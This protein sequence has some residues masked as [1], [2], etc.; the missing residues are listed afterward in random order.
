MA[1]EHRSTEEAHLDA[2]RGLAADGHVK[3]DGGSHVGVLRGKAQRRC[4]C[5]ERRRAERGCVR[6]G[7]GPREAHT[8]GRCFGIIFFRKSNCMIAALRVRDA[9]A[10]SFR[11]FVTATRPRRQTRLERRT[12]DIVDDV[13]NKELAGGE[14]QKSFKEL[15][16]VRM[17]PKGTTAPASSVEARV[18]ESGPEQQHDL[19]A[20]DRSGSQ[21]CGPCA[22]GAR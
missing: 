14:L 2:A 13:G 1:E 15:S 16:D 4:L 10:P 18:F 8:V 22:R 19:E 9:R 6:T 17:H 11:P 12:E 20:N 5:E 7:G 3:V 21:K